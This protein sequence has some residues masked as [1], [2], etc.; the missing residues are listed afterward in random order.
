MPSL[1]VSSSVE[2][3]VKLRPEPTST[4]G[5]F[6]VTFKEGAAAAGIESLR[7]TSGLRVCDAREFDGDFT[8]AAAGDADCL[9]YGAIGAA[10]IGGDAAADRGLAF[11]PD[12]DPGSPILSI[13]P[14]HF[15]FAESEPTQNPDFE[16]GFTRMQQVILEDLGTLS[17]AAAAS[18]LA[19]A[20]PT[21]GLTACRVPAS[22]FD[23]NGI[24]VAIL[25]TG[26]DLGHPAFAGR[27][28]VSASFT[29]QPVQDAGGHGTH[30]TGTACGPRTPPGIMTRYGIAFRS[31]IYVGKVLS[32]GAGGTQ[33]Q[34][35]SGLHWAIVQKCHVILLP[36]GMPSVAVIPSYTSAGAAALAKGCLVIA[37]A[38]WRSH[39][40]GQLAP[41]DAPANS[42]TILSV[43]AIDQALG[44][45]P[46]SAAGKID[47]V[48]P[49]V[50]VLSSFPRPALH[51]TW[52]G[53]ASAAAHA[54]GC[55][56]L[57]AQTDVA[58]RGPALRAKLL[59]NAKPLA[60]PPS[61]AG[62]G[63]VQAP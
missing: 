30:M 17:Q 62:A 38:G 51:Q 56:A 28:I 50:N 24:R 1:Q 49:G 22:H 3:L 54:A 31:A 43:G 59:A 58:L 8:P 27:A 60:F 44:I 16:R 7:S 37:P 2:E 21:W 42:P 55:A 34:I 53:T 35:L 26:L 14:E 23:G 47:I 33:A 4:T 15:L 61:D 13:D 41:A 45:A 63:L 5:R 10:L 29:G 40:P 39:R 57:W 52:S 48:A 9:A 11:G 6:I 32:N 36:L 19:S 18:V 20:A 46:F 12:S 25:D